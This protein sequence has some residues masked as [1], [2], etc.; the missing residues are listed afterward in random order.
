[1]TKHQDNM[2]PTET[3]GGKKMRLWEIAR[4][5]EPM[6]SVKTS[7]PLKI[8]MFLL[9]LFLFNF[10]HPGKLT[11]PWKITIFNRIYIFKLLIFHGFQLSY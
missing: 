7:R 3:L 2:C 1:M 6:R 11:W 5:S 10:T 8:D 4:N 9:D